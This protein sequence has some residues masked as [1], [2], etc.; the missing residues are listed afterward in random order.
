MIRIR[1]CRICSTCK[2]LRELSIPVDWD[3]KV[4]G[5]WLLLDILSLTN[6]KTLHVRNAPTDP[7]YKLDRLP[8][9]HDADRDMASD[10]LRSCRPFYDNRFG[11][12]HTSSLQTLIIGPLLYGN[13]WSWQFESHSHYYHNGYAHFNQPCIFSVEYLGGRFGH[14]LL[15]VDQ[16]EFTSLE[17]VREEIDHTR[18]LDSLWLK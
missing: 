17:A 13:R 3:S 14:V 11:A 9:D 6:L 12:E 7:R 15:T 2:E 16:L 1:R 18:V 4:K 10:F 5:A 8:P